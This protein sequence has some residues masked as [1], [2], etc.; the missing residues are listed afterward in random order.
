[1]TTKKILSVTIIIAMAAMF[2]SSS[3]FV[4]PLLA[5]TADKSTDVSKDKNKDKSKDDGTTTSTLITQSTSNCKDKGKDDTSTGTSSSTD[6]AKSTD[7]SKSGTKDD[8]S[9]GTSS[10]TSSNFKEFQKCLSDAQGTKGFATNSQ[11]KDCY[12]SIYRPLASSSSTSSTSP[13]KTSTITP[14]DFSS[15]MDFSKL[16]N[17][18]Q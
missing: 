12:N 7:D 6:S 18:G 3:A 11:I 4:N 2:F 1:M 14:T 10:S 9:T 15:P 17:N 5:K 13:A 8:T 16:K